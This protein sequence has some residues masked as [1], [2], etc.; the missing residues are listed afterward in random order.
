[1]DINKKGEMAMG[2]LIIFIAMIL[3]AAVAAAVL[4]T[5]TSSLQSKAL[6]TGRATTTE[7]ATNIKIMQVFG[8]NASSNNN[9]ENL[10]ISTQLA[11]GSNMVRFR[12]MLLTLGLKEI[13]QDYLYN[14]SA[15]C[16]DV[17]GGDY[18][19]DYIMNSSN[20]VRGY[21]SNGDVV[22]ICIVSPRSINESEDF[23][24]SLVPKSG[25]PVTLAFTTPT[26]MNMQTEK[27]YP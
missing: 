4:I 25:N 23:T 27:I 26:V 20:S 14:Q 11:A 1:L 2:T 7:V 3:I 12:D 13:S 24:I 5:T 19:V 15:T 22:R 6:D 16:S 18:A 10:Y 17:A 21:L 9:L 8:T